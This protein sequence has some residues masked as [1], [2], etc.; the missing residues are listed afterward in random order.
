MGLTAGQRPN[1]VTV[2]PA[3]LR[4]LKKVRKKERPGVIDVPGKNDYYDTVTV[5]R[6]TS[7]GTAADVLD[8]P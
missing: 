4:R 6:H 3:E 7:G 5:I 1:A 2:P 8:L